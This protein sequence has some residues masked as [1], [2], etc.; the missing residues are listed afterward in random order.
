MASLIA[1]PFTVQML[2]RLHADTACK[3]E[4]TP[5]TC[6]KQRQTYVSNFIQNRGVE[7]QILERVKKGEGEMLK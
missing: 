5:E 7:I 1:A 4:Y 2:H 3:T 6:L